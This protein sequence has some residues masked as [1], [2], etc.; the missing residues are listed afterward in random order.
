MN[1]K[2]LFN[3]GDFLLS[4]TALGL[5]GC[6]ATSA[7][8]PPVI[9]TKSPNP[10]EEYL[11]LYPDAITSQ[12]LYAG[13]VLFTNSLVN[14]VLKVISFNRL[15]I[16]I[17]LFTDTEAAEAQLPGQPIGLQPKQ[18]TNFQPWPTKDNKGIMFASGSSRIAVKQ[19]DE[20]I[21]LRLFSRGIPNATSELSLDSRGFI[22]FK[23]N[24]LTTR[25]APLS[26]SIRLAAFRTNATSTSARK[27]TLRAR[28]KVTGQTAYDSI[29]PAGGR[30][31]AATTRKAML[32]SH[33][34]TADATTVGSGVATGGGGGGGGVIVSACTLGTMAPL[35]VARKAASASQQA[36]SALLASATSLVAI[37]R[38]YES[39]QAS[40][41]EWIVDV[42]LKGGLSLPNAGGIV[43]GAAQSNATVAAVEIAASLFTLGGTVDALTSLREGYATFLRASGAEA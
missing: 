1:R 10:N 13:T 42:V 35:S 33:M 28:K 39:V 23:N 22:T 26:V 3:R 36:S 2:Q 12:V 20:A 18:S 29:R 32:T 25:S 19:I 21:R 38:N 8:R 11:V 6:S 4:G 14:N 27:V 24:Q 9:S 37:V 40:L 16:S 43:P 15:S 31:A 34:G 41:S 5:A 17:P 30:N 7:S